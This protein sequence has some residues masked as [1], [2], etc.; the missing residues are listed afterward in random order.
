MYKRIKPFK[1]VIEGTFAGTFDN[2][3]YFNLTEGFAVPFAYAIKPCRQWNSLYYELTMSIRTPDKRQKIIQRKY[4]FDANDEA[5]AEDAF[6][7]AYE[8]RNAFILKHYDIN[9]LDYL[10]CY[11][12][13][14]AL[15]KRQIWKPIGDEG[16][17]CD[18]SG[19]RLMANRNGFTLALAHPFRD[20][21]EY[22]GGEQ[23]YR[24]VAVS[25]TAEAVVNA[26]KRLLPHWLSY[27]GQNRKN[28]EPVEKYIHL[29]RLEDLLT[30]NIYKQSAKGK[31]QK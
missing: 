20:F 14:F 23:A 10:T 17:F 16:G 1:E 7:I 26:V 8:E 15:R 22:L 27:Y 21:K 25:P 24:T 11:E 12:P 2:I 31:S 9:Y 18:L 28:V 13:A 4:Y 3:P 30:S 19:F 29:R 5:S 6:E